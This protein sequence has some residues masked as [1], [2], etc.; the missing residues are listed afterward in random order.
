[1][2]RRLLIAALLISVPALSASAC[3][4]FFTRHDI[5]DDFNGA[6]SVYA[7]DVDGDGDLDVL[8][9]GYYND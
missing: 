8:A 1:M 7:S 6:R 2:T 3:P 5:H 4:Q 9:A